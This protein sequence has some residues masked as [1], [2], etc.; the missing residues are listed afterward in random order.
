MIDDR[1]HL[2]ESVVLQIRGSMDGL[3]PQV[4]RI[5][6]EVDPY[7]TMIRIQTMQE[8]VSNRLDQQRT[9]AQMTG[10]L[11]F[12]RSSWPPLGL[13]GVT[14]TLWNGAP[15]R[16][17]V[18][19]A[20]GRQPR[21]CGAHGFTWSVPADP[22][23]PSDRNSGFHRLLAPHRRAALSREGL[24]SIRPDRVGPC[25]RDLRVSSPASSLRSAPRPSIR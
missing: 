16:S 14:L 5:F 2:I 12:S 9:V 1:T 13:Y 6:A 8:H 23:W 17:A 22:H 7:L 25:T 11:G 19:M 24:G 15:R 18:R 20:L 10:L 3:E 4:R 21:Q